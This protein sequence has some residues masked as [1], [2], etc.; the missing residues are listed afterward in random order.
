MSY[1]PRTSGGTYNGARKMLYEAMHPLS[2]IRHKLACERLLD[3]MG[4]PTSLAER[5]RRKYLRMKKWLETW[6]PF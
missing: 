6:V 5:M 3:A 1:H 2:P 4:A